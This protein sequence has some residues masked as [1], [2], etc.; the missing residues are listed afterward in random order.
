[1]KNVSLRTDCTTR[2]HT[3]C[4]ISHF[5][6]LSLVWSSSLIHN[7]ALQ[8]FRGYQQRDETYRETD[9]HKNWRLSSSL[10]HTECHW[11]CADSSHI[12]I[13][14]YK[15]Q[16]WDWGRISPSVWDSPDKAWNF[17]VARL[18]NTF[19]TL[20]SVSL[21][22]FWLYSSS[23]SSS[24]SSLCSAGQVKVPFPPTNVH[25]CEVS[26]TYVVLS[27]AEPEPRGS[28]PL[29]FY[30]ERVSLNSNTHTHRHTHNCSY[31][32]TSW[33]L[34]WLQLSTWLSPKPTIFLLKDHVQGFSKSATNH[35]TADHF[36]THTLSFQIEFSARVLVLGRVKP[37]EINLQRLGSK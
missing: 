19:W 18:A 2:R 32:N 33:G 16:R 36:P 5:T 11:K 1:M 22:L 31:Y 12:G 30:V 3:G 24:S 21:T 34:G 6:A 8:L 10:S 23:S 7:A 25:A 13:L 27:W 15:E 9:R 14:L 4:C 28:E 35:F 29:T 17:P 37:W 20:H 26:D